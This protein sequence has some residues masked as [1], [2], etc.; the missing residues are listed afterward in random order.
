MKKLALI[1]AVAGIV[2]LSSCGKKCYTCETLAGSVE[3]CSDS[4]NKTQ[5]NAA[6]TACELGGG[7]WK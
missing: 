4:L 1:I 7:T 5:L 2:G 3:Y 6:E